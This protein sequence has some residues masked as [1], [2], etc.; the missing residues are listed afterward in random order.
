ME[1][2]DSPNQGEGVQEPIPNGDDTN[3]ENSSTRQENDKKQW[4]KRLKESVTKL[5]IPAGGVQGN[6]DS[7]ASKKAATTANG[8]DADQDV[9]LFQ[10]RS[11]G[12][13]AI[14]NRISNYFKK[15]SKSTRANGSSSAAT[16]ATTSSTSM[17]SIDVAVNNIPGEGNEK[18]KDNSEKTSQMR[19]SIPNRI[20]SRRF[21][22]PTSPSGQSG[23]PGGYNLFGATA[24]NLISRL[25]SNVS[26]TGTSSTRESLTH[27]ARVD[28]NKITSA[29]M[30]RAA[31][32]R[33]YLPAHLLK[34]IG[35]QKHEL[36]EDTLID[37]C[38]RV[39]DP[40]TPIHLQGYLDKQSFSNINQWKKR[41]LVLKGEF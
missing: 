41:Y 20:I 25:H 2:S 28:M 1:S 4:M 24:N 40:T 23:Q 15:I 30:K 9:P 5:V 27:Q 26:T 13:G 17:A 38:R 16:G 32:A 33:Y 37:A 22:P 18:Q 36:D 10:T 11:I 6:G 19:L 35:A 31:N 39:Y 29:V 12:S 7:D 3:K 21:T 34:K 14:T 8:D